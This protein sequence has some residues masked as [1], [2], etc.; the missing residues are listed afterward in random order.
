MRENN[1]FLIEWQSLGKTYPKDS[2]SHDRS[3]LTTT[4]TTTTTKSIG[5]KNM[6]RYSNT[7]IETFCNFL[8]T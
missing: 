6:G 8:Q 5:L 3:I 1:F 4:V 7:K 2:L